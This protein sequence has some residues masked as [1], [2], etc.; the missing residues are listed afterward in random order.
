MCARA[1]R[2]Q[3]FI[4]LENYLAKKCKISLRNFLQQ[5]SKNLQQCGKIVCFLQ[6][7]SSELKIQKF[8]QLSIVTFL[9]RVKNN[10]QLLKTI[11]N[12]LS[13]LIEHFSNKPTLF[14]GDFNAKSRV[15]GSELEDDENERGHCC[16]AKF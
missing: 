4:Q 13:Q 7:F 5:K 8:L 9:P 14:L 12:K 16:L 6:R 10:S 2:L 3:R 11:Q 1:I 15:W